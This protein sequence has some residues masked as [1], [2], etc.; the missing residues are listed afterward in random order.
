VQSLG[1]QIAQGLVLTT[2]F[3]WDQ[4]DETRAWTKR[5]RAKKDKLPNMTIAG[6]YSATLHYLKAVQAAGT[7]EPKAVMAKMRE[8]PIND[9]M[10]KNGKLREDGRVIRDLYLFQVKTPAESKGPD[11]L[12]KLVATVPGEQAFRPLKDGHCPYIK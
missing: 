6:T 8:M 2:A 1:L 10:T 9:V 3:Y 7:D 12:Y 4:N 5:F 11:D